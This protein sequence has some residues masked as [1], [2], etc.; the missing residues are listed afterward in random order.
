MKTIARTKTLR[1]LSWLSDE[2]QM[3][4]TKTRYRL[5]EP[6]CT[7]PTETL[8][9]VNITGGGPSRIVTK[10]ALVRPNIVKSG[11]LTAYKLLA[12]RQRLEQRPWAKCKL[13]KASQSLAA[14][15]SS[16]VRWQLA[17]SALARLPQRFGKLSHSNPCGPGEDSFTPRTHE[18]SRREQVERRLTRVSLWV[19][20]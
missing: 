14:D 10:T 1:C 4:H 19:I 13:P 5:L 18:D 2:G 9:P 17:C 15:P 7:R 6:G 3:N 16:P 20:L 8:R 12:G 11:K